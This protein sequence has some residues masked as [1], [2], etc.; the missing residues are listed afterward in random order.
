M[1]SRFLRLWLRY[2]RPRIEQLRFWWT[3]VDWSDGSISPHSYY[4][5]PYLTPFPEIS[6]PRQKMRW[7]TDWRQFYWQSFLHPPRPH[8]RCRTISQFR[9]VVTSGVVPEW[10]TD[11][12]GEG[13]PVR[14]SKPKS[15]RNTNLNCTTFRSRNQGC[16]TIYYRL[17]YWTFF[18]T[19][20]QLELAK[21]WVLFFKSLSLS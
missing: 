3:D 17:L 4:C 14:S 13:L 8:P 10:A 21:P 2:R 11:Q 19:L 7:K 20:N 5:Y 15:A 12:S 6:R 1:Q 18:R 16:I 9:L